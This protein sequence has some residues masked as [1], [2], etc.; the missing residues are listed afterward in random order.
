M[1]T[2]KALIESLKVILRLIVLA[3]VPVLITYFAALPY[4]WAIVITLLLRWLDSYLH[5][6]AKEQ[7][8]ITRNEGL[9]GTHGL[10]GF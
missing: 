8:K 4:Q 7:P 6:M 3:V 10:T 5:E 9:L 2:D 1:Q